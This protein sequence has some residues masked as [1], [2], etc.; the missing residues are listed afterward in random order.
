VKNVN[1][2]EQTQTALRFVLFK[3]YLTLWPFHFGEAR[4][5]R[6]LSRSYRWNEWPRQ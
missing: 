4:L 5:R 3:Q 2:I 1:Q 6:R